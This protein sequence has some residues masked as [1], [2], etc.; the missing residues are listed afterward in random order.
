M[1]HWSAARGQLDKQVVVK[2]LSLQALALGQRRRRQKVGLLRFR[3]PVAIQVGASS[4]QGKLSAW[5]RVLGTERPA[6]AP[7]RLGKRSP[8]YIGFSPTPPQ[9]AKRSN[10]QQ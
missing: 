5:R 4:I 10:A 2:S 6:T 8:E 7:S 3:S 1:H 9:A